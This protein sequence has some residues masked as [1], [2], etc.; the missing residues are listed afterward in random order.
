MPRV[1]DAQRHKL[2]RDPIRDA[3]LVLLEF[4][5]DGSP[6][7]HRAVANTEDFDWRGNT[8]YRRQVGIELPNTG[9]GETS[10]KLVTS[11]IDRI[12]GRALSAATQ[13][14]NVRLILIDSSVPDDTPLIDTR[15]LLVIPSA[16]G[17][18]EITVD[19]GPRASLQE[20]V[21]FV[22]TTQAAFPGVWLA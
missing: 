11:N 18:L 2:N 22:P 3:H 4:Q 12:L 10:A 16:S 13:R 8:Y 15:N 21:P 17:S 20:P 9:K 7:V 6:T 5:E 1:T 14:I 19:L